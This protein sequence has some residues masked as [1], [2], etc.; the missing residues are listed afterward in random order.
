MSQGE[1]GRK[2]K[3]Q[4]SIRHQSQSR[5]PPESPR[6]LHH[7]LHAHGLEEPPWQRRRDVP[8]E[9]LPSLPIPSHHKQT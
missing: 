4:P 7:C 8:M 1:G 6:P 5:G 3:E 9:A 2:G